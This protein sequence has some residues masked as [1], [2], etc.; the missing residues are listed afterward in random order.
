MHRVYRREIPATMC[1]TP[2]L[3]L[4]CT[5][6]YRF[7]LRDIPD[8]ATAAELSPIYSPPHRQ[9]WRALEVIRSTC[10]IYVY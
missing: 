3:E 9:V 2:I 6:I 1:Y 4:G 10:P 7:L 5:Y 8:L